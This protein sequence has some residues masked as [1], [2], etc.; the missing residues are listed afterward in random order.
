[1]RI[2]DDDDDDDNDNDFSINRLF[3]FRGCR[4][5]VRRIMVLYNIF[6]YMCIVFVLNDF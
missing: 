1:M 4:C 5:P 6:V 2:R 3:L